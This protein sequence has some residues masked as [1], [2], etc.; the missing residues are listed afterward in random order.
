MK[1]SIVPDE[2][3]FDSTEAW[4]VIGQI[5]SKPDS[6]IGLVLSWLLLV[7]CDIMMLIYT[8]FGTRSARRPI[9]IKERC[10]KLN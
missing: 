7:V 10:L 3:S 4:R 9:D 8:R 6:V 2:R 1:I 5:L